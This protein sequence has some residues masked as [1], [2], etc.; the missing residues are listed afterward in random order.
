MMRRLTIAGVLILLSLPSRPA[1]AQGSLAVLSGEPVKEVQVQ[2]TEISPSEKESLLPQAEGS[3]LVPEAVGEG[4][5]NLYRTGRFKRV[6]VFAKRDGSGLTLLYQVTPRQYLSEI[7]FE[8][9][10]SIRDGE[11]LSRTDLSLREEVTEQRL[12]ANTGKIRDYYLQRGFLDCE[13]SFRVEPDFREQKRVVFQIREGTQGVVSDVRLEGEPGMSR[14]KLLSLIASMPGEKLDGRTLR[15]D[16]ERIVAHYKEDFFLTPRVTY[17]LS[18]DPR[19]QGGRIVTFFLERGPHFTFEVQPPDVLD[20]KWVRKRLEKGLVGAASISTAREEVEKTVI[21]RFFEGGYPFASVRWEEDSPKESE[22][23]ITMTLQVET[24]VFVGDVE[25]SGAMYFSEDE[26]KKTLGLEPGSPF[27]QAE[28]DSGVRDLGRSYYEQGFL[29]AQVVVDPLE[30]IP[31]GDVQDVWIGVAVQE[32]EQSVIGN[33]QIRSDLEHSGVFSEIIQLGSNDPYV[34]ES[35][36]KAREKIL[37][38]LSRAGYLYANVAISEPARRENNLVDVLL[39]VHEG[40]K[41]HL[42]TVII[43]GNEGVNPR[44]IRLAID[45]GPGETLT[46]EKILKAQERIYR[47][48]VMSSVNVELVDPQEPSE[49]KDLIVTVRE[50]PRYVVGFRMGY[51]SE[52]KVRGEASVTHRNV[53]GMARSLT[54]KGKKSDIEQR[55]SLLYKHP[56]F[57]SRPIDMSASLSDIIEERGSY[58]RDAISASVDF[59]RKMSER[60]EVGLGYFFEG[61]RLFDVSPGAQLSPDDDGK[62][63]VAAVIWE[64]IYDSRDDILD[65]WSGLLGD[66]RFEV[67]SQGLGSATEY[68]KFELASHRYVPL[69]KG[70]VL[71][72]L[73]RLGSVKSYGESEEVII[74]KRF[75]LGGQNSVRGYV[76]DGLGPK[77][78]DGEP[79]GGNYM[80]NGNFEVRFPVYR[81]L[82][83]VGFVDSGSIWLKGSRQGF[84]LRS[85]TGAGLRWSSPIGPLSLDYGYKLNPDPEDVEDR[86]RWHLSIGHAF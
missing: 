19:V 86:Y 51:G 40:P 18:P 6:D 63:D 59:T 41:V 32:G 70:A 14:T 57:N 68:L 30:F 50:R 78:A 49:R 74:S 60:T 73:L 25:V 20:G 52:D 48:G 16:V 81:T 83:G 10:I 34:P 55:T 79:I 61:L 12:L 71:A 47:L 44:I 80:F 65:P 8:G 29:E 21:S 13:V 33:L 36:E 64:A 23:H 69:G 46:Q 7:R 84:H 85:S 11:L 4:V 1:A 42:G 22:R 3:V 17:S 76:L 45:L 31:S 53:G 43:T 58:S 72:G 5:R 9:N 75:F 54:L 82:R 35:V 66:F 67:A 39:T 37:T 24:R 56:W 28:L 26:A 27:V 15:K 77:D 62:T 2:G 38:W